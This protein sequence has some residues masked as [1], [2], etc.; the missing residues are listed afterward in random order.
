MVGLAQASSTRN[1]LARGMIRMNLAQL[2]VW[3]FRRAPFGPALE[4]HLDKCAALDLFHYLGE[5]LPALKVAHV[6]GLVE[7]PRLYPAAPNPMIQGTEQA[8]ASASN[9]IRLWG[10]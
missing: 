3:I 10:G 4:P 1:H 9:V 7:L 2:L 6:L 8:R 5:D